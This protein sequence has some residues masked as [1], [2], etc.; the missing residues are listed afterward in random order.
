M[1]TLDEYYRSDDGEPTA[2]LEA[3]E[4][5][6]QSA[7]IRNEIGSREADSADGA[8]TTLAIIALAKEVAALRHTIAAIHL[9]KPHE[10]SAEHL[11]RIFSKPPTKPKPTSRAFGEGI[12]LTDPSSFECPTL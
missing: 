11:A 12:D 8:C 1:T 4:A 7:R 10:F 3:A 5:A 2:A 9:E 6:E